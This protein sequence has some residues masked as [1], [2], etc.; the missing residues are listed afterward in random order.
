M[1]YL[2]FQF[3]EDHR[4]AIPITNEGRGFQIGRHP[5]S[6]LAIHE[7]SSTS[8]RHCS[9]RRVSKQDPYVL[10]DLGSSNGTYVNGARVWSTSAVL[11]DGDVLLIG[12]AEFIFQ[13][14]QQDYEL[15]SSTSII[16]KP[17]CALPPSAALRTSRPENVEPS[18]MDT[19]QLDRNRDL[20]VIS[21][22]PRPS[23]PDGPL[24][25]ET[26]TDVNG[27]EIIRPVGSS[28]YATVYL[29]NQTALR[30]TVAMKVYTAGAVRGA[31]EAERFIASVQ[32]AG[33]IQHPNVLSCLD[34]GT[35]G[36]FY[37]FTMPYVADGSVAARLAERGAFA[38]ADA[39]EMMVRLA[40]AVE[41]VQG[42]YRLI[43]YNIRPSNILLADHGE[44]VIADYGLAE[45]VATS[46]QVNRKSFF[47]HPAYMCAE[48]VLDRCPDWTCDMY[49]LGIVFY[50]MLFGRVPFEADTPYRMIEKHLNEPLSFPKNVAISE[51]MRE[52]V[53]RMLAKKPE[54]RYSNWQGLIRE[55]E[56]RKAIASGK[57]S[58]AASLPTSSGNGGAGRG[59]MGKSQ[60][61]IQK[62]VRSS[63]PPSIKLPS[64]SSSASVP[65]KKP[66]VLKK[67][68]RKP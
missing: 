32:A 10:D 13:M 48:Q 56:V 68:I 46:L 51:G 36:N 18:V 43:H 67:V 11:H 6:D 17:E 1:A 24:V 30:R 16:V 49:A 19:V 15:T 55:L 23:V 34:T 58:V 25:L 65:A 53:R 52:V 63:A 3:D 20:P 21:R 40:Y 54:E 38:E 41:H 7:D 50:E 22:P 57:A 60:I 47:G 29:A 59:D 35:C 14:D 39:R 45:W 64:S 4:E 2:I 66:I 8:R 44:P 5:E 26:G 61:R 31:T 27:Y 62:M 28:Q 37:Y 42:K 9:I 12:N 33:R